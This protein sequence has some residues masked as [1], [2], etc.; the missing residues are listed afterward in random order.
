MNRQKS[1]PIICPW[2]TYKIKPL[3]ITQKDK[4]TPSSYK[5]KEKKITCI[6]AIPRDLLKSKIQNQRVSHHIS[7][8][9]ISDPFIR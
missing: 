1:Q 4:S 8:V 5:K 2:N 6:I 9:Q 7:I 3:T